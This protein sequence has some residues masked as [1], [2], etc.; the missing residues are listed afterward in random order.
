MGN[1]LSSSG[2]EAGIVLTGPEEDFDEVDGAD[3]DEDADDWT[4][5]LDVEDDDDE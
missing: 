3:Q 4:D 2:E 5:C 1:G